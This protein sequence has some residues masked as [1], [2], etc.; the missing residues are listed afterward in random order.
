MS[1]GLNDVDEVRRQMALIRRDLHENVREVVATAGAATDWRRL[2]AMHPWPALGAALALGYLVVPRR[3]V[4]AAIVPAAAVE[5]AVEAV[6][7][8]RP[9]VAKGI[10]GAALGFAGPLAMRAAQGY[11]IQFLEQWIAQQQHAAAGMETGPAPASAPPRPPRD[12]W[13][14][15][16]TPI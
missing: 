15:G 7:T 4:S 8:S 3:R 9:S 11:A 13:P 16:A 10:L 14:G 5:A 1:T 12:P 2:V 6:Q